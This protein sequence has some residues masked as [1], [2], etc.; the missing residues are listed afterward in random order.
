MRSFDV[1]FDLRLN[2]RL[3]KQSWGWWF[4]TLSHPLWRHCNKLLEPLCKF[5]YTLQTSTQEHW[6][7]IKLCI[8]YHPWQLKAKSNFLDISW[9]K[10]SACKMRMCNIKLVQQ[11]L[12]NP[13]CASK[14][15][16]VITSNTSH[17]RHN[18]HDG[19]SNHQP[20]G[21]LLNCL[22]RSR[23][24]KTSK[25]CVTG[26]C[27]GNSPGPVNSS[28]ERLV[29]WKMFPF[30]DV[31]NTFWVF[32][33]VMIGISTLIAHTKINSPQWFLTRNSE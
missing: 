9:K 26:L 19:V 22:F 23:S 25:L 5:L 24:K 8:T 10:N 18:D 27:V 17:W 7:C 32:Y 16:Y 6:F 2:K 12:A 11:K 15:L 33:Q 29:T 21:C 30:D 31:I 13:Q 1:F 28:H 14:C 20:H 3:S 4:E